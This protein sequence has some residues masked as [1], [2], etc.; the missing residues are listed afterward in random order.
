MRTR[1][2]G[3]DVTGPQRRTKEVMSMRTAFGGDVIP[4]G[5]FHGGDEIPAGG[6]HGGDE[7]PAG[8]FH[9]I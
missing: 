9:S 5:G 6:F 3:S 4:S 7:I 2:I 1:S 8:G